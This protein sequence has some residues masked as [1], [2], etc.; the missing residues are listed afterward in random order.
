MQEQPYA[1]LLNNLFLQKEQLRLN[2]WLF[3]ELMQTTLED[4]YAGHS[5]L[6][7]ILT[8]WFLL[9]ESG[10]D[11]R[12]TYDNQQA[13][14]YVY[15]EESIYETP[16]IRDEGRLFVNLNS[17]YERSGNQKQKLRMLNFKPQQNGRSFSFDL[18]L[19]PN[20]P[21][22]SSEKNIRF[23]WRGQQY[24]LTVEVNEGIR[25]LMAN[26]PLIDERRY[27]EIPFSES[28]RHSLLP[29]LRHLLEGKSE[30]ESLEILAALTRSGFSYQEDHEQ[31]G[32]SK[33]MAAEEVLLYSHS[34]C[35]DRVALF[36]QLVREL[37]DLPVII[38]AWPDHLSAA[39]STSQQIGDQVINFQNHQ[40]FVCDPTGPSNSWDVGNPPAEFASLPFE[41]IYSN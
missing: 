14:L 10:F 6:K 23:N 24:E 8:A 30:K 4:I 17:L 5:S 33:P 26:Y 7:K 31:F 13:Y 3:F 40:Y 34:D 25:S 18:S 41:V 19:L 2:D 11:T 28:L 20:F 15:T 21:T 9:S 22:H 35:E 16:M 32:T 12:L 27:F 29:Q 39:V 37:L 1:P 36:Y 38:I